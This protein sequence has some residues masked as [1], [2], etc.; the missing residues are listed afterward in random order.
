MK[1]IVRTI[2][3]LW[4]EPDLSRTF[5]SNPEEARKLAE[6]SKATIC[7]S[8]KVRSHAMH[9]DNGTARQKAKQK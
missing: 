5:A 9:Q 4:L 2:V 1:D 8:A 6:Q 7:G 3:A